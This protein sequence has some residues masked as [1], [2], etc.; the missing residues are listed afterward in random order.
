MAANFTK[1]GSTAMRPQFWP[2]TSKKLVE[3]SGLVI[4][5]CWNWVAFYDLL[6]EIER[7]DK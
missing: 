7:V 5:A 4:E 1:V 6:E 3:P 2:V